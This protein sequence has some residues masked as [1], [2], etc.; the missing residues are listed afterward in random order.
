MMR[1]ILLTLT[2]CTVAC[3]MFNANPV[4]AQSKIKALIIDGQNN[5]NWR[6]TTPVLKDIMEKSGRFTVDVA[7]SPTKSDKDAD[8][9]AY[10]KKMA[11]FKPDFAKYDVIIGN[12]NS[13]ETHDDWSPDTKKAFEKYIENGG[14]FVSYHATDNS[15]PDWVEYNKMTGLGGWDRGH[16][17]EDAG[18]HLYWEEGKAVTSNEKGRPRGTHGP[19]WA[20]PIDVRDSKHPVTSGLPATFRHC[21]DELYD[22][23]WGPAENVTILATAY[24]D[25]EHGGSGRHEPMLMA[26]SYGKGRI[27]HTTLGHDVQ[28]LKSVSFIV[29]FLRGAEW[30]ATGKVTIPVPADFPGKDEPTFRE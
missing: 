10:N 13:N 26:I 8:A 29:T 7:T 19:Q 28:H 17:P 24:A 23:M 30:A 11:T 3:L 4:Q 2:V 27:F 21:S 22:H 14:G 20:F 16:M 25:K 5:H 9:D 12:Y 6:G 1:K 15:F 18:K